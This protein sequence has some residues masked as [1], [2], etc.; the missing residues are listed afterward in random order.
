MAEDRASP[1]AIAIAL[2]VGEAIESIGGA[3]LMYDLVGRM[4]QLGIG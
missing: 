1:D 3:H 4:K 2:R